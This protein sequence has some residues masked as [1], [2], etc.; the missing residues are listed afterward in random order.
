MYLNRIQY[1]H[2]SCKTANISTREAVWTALPMQRASCTSHHFQQNAGVLLAASPLLGQPPAPP[3]TEV[4]E[5]PQKSQFPLLLTR[6]LSSQR[7]CETPLETPPPSSSKPRRGWGP[8]ARPP[9]L[10]TY[11]WCRHAAGGRGA[12]EG[13][14][15][16]RTDGQTDGTGQREGSGGG[17]HLRAARRGPRP[18]TARSSSSSS[19]G[20][21]E[22]RVAPE[23]PGV[24][25]RCH[26]TR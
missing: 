2:K 12:T 26:T 21:G 3:R 23:P 6:T 4:Q 1:I 11:P 14:T 9:L 25:T 20:G 5:H 7:R 8:T 15:D 18:G 22:G 19:A 13:R 17:R 24:A 16:R 10:S